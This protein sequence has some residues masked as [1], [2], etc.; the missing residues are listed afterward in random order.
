MYHRRVDGDPAAGWNALAMS[1]FGSAMRWRPPGDEGS[2]QEPMPTPRSGLAIAAGYL[3]LFSI[4]PF[5]GPFALLVGCLAWRQ[6]DRRPELQGRWRAKFGV[7]AG[8]AGT[9]LWAILW[10]RGRIG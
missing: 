4:L 6:L 1:K 8:A 5:V 2:A 10:L 9:V 3:G 7:V